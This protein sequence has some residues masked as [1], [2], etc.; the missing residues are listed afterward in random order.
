MSLLHA[1]L[2][3]FVWVG[4]AAAQDDAVAEFKDYLP[5][6]IASF[7]D[8]E[9]DQVPMMFLW[10]SNLAVSPAG[11]LVLQSHL[12][13]LM[14]EG[15]SDFEAAKKAFQTDLGEAATGDL[16][17]SQ[18]H[19]LSYRASRLNMTPVGFFPFKFGGT[20]SDDVASVRGTLKILDENIAYPVNHV[21]IR[22]EREEGICTYQQ[23]ALLL[24]DE[25][26]FA[27]TYHV[28]DVADEFYRITHWGT[29]QVTAVPLFEAGCRTNQLTMN[30]TTQ[31]FYEIT[32]NL[33]SGD[34]DTAVGVSI[35]KLE[36]PRIAQIVDGEE[37][38]AAEFK[39]IQEET[40]GYF[41]SAFRARVDALKP[42][43]GAGDN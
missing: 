4:S 42:A 3:S 13:S 18:V 16:T 8:E 9:R 11:D 29:D 12:N 20:I 1:F 21:K 31:E 30:F 17:V 36:R 39:Q 26:S 22:C 14:Y 24:P 10:A 35:P 43:E 38:I 34:C 2:L 32:R 6:E 27:Q 15:L 37:L 41:S 23:V 5:Q 25:T 33:S 19:A 28:S 40:Y 7:S